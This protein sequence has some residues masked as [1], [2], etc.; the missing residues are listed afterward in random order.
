M[1]TTSL[2]TA[3]QRLLGET[4]LSRVAQWRQHR[5]P[6]E[7]MGVQTQAPEYCPALGKEPECCPLGTATA[8]N[9]VPGHSPIGPTADGQGPRRLQA[10]ALT[11]KQCLIH[12]KE[13]Q[14]LKP[15]VKLSNLGHL[16]LDHLSY[17]QQF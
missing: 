12:I 16:S 8:L 5:L 15:N 7:R 2:T 14:L 13:L 6:W 11:R 9:K 3:P 4:A 10:Q 1:I 17:S